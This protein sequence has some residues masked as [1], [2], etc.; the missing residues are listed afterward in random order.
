MTREGGRSGLPFLEWRVR[1][2]SIGAGLGLGGIFLDQPYLIW[3]AI[4]VLGLGVLLRFLPV[5]RGHPAADDDDSQEVH[6]AE[7]PPERRHDAEH[8]SE[9]DPESDPA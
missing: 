2:F 3:G 8:D 6:E 1:I 7:D 9:P 4:S 5:G